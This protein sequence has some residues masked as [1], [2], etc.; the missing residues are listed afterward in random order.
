MI[1]VLI[2]CVAKVV[3][4]NLLGWIRYIAIHNLWWKIYVVVNG[5]RL[6]MYTIMNDLLCRIFLSGQQSYRSDKQL[7]DNVILLCV[8]C[9]T[10]GINCPQNGWGSLS[11]DS[12]S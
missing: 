12:E 5:L 10:N 9:D 1:E 4:K 6:V 2:D 8:V 3:I 7:T 11:Y